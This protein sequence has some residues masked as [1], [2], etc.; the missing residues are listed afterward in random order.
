EPRSG[1]KPIRQTVWCVVEH[2][3][4]LAPV[5]HRSDGLSLVGFVHPSSGRTLFHLATSVTSARFEAELAACA[6]AV[7]ADPSRDIV[8]VL[9][10]AGWH[11][12][13]RL[14]VPDPMHRVLLP[15]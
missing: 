10:R 5:Q 12:M 13:Q 15:P 3:R 4:P 1:L 11:R 9:E 14:R 7:D 2:Q 8:L 6:T